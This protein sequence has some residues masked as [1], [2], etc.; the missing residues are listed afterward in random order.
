M[1]VESH[2][3]GHVQVLSISR[4]AEGVLDD[5]TAADGVPLDDLKF[6]RR[7]PSR[8]L[9]HA[10][11]YGDLADVMHGGGHQQVLDIVLCQ[12]IPETAP[13]PQR[14]CQHLHIG[15]GAADVSAGAAV[16]ALDQD[17]KAHH[18]LPVVMGELP[19]G[20]V[21]LIQINAQEKNGHAQTGYQSLRHQ[22]LISASQQH[23]QQ[24]GE[25]TGPLVALDI[26]P[27][28]K[29]DHEGENDRNTHH[30]EAGIDG[31]THGVVGQPACPVFQGTNIQQYHGNADGVGSKQEKLVTFPL[32]KSLSGHQKI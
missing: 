7:Q 13:V 22:H 19:Q 29:K 32:G 3:V 20:G 31:H 1:V 4:V 27:A 23:H 21:L 18:H 25:N 15:S 28:A 5:L 12:N 2:I 6:L 14:L 17:G 8:L 16:L 9:Q 11:R 30:N 10:V 24:I 26:A